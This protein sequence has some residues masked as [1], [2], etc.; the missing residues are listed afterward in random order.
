MI[1]YREYK[2]TKLLAYAMKQKNP[3]NQI[4][5]ELLR[6]GEFKYP[7]NTHDMF[8]IAISKNKK[9]FSK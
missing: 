7:V 3:L 9:K 4:K 8:L 2:S 5:M 1:E 6:K